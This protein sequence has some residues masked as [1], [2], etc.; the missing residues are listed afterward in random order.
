MPADARPT[1]RRSLPMPIT[2]FASPALMI[3]TPASCGLGSLTESAFFPFAAAA[4]SGGLSAMMTMRGLMSR[5]R[6]A[7][8]RRRRAGYRATLIS[9]PICL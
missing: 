4:A 7:I 3:N 6:G 2:I 8:Y 5:K 1:A 9:S